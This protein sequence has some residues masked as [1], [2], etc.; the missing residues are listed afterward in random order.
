MRRLCLAAGYRDADIALVNANRCRSKANA[1]PTVSQVRACRPFVLRTIEVL[2][3]AFVFALGANAAKGLTN[4]G[5]AS[6]TSLRGKA[7]LVPGLSGVPSDGVS[8]GPLPAP[9][10]YVTYHPVAILHGASHLESRIVED[11]KRVNL[12]SL[13]YPTD[14]IPS[15]K[16]LAIDAEWDALGKLLCVALASTAEAMIVRPEPIDLDTETNGV[17]VRP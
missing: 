11:L 14:G 4:I 9:V 8:F 12:P 16:I 1:A 10:V 15:G 5:N 6:V 7:V 3:P 13:P 17:S 2:R